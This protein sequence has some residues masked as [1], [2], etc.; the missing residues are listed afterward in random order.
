MNHFYESC[1]LCGPKNIKS[2]CIASMLVNLDL[3][4]GLLIS[5]NVTSFRVIPSP[6]F[7]SYAALSV[8]NLKRLFPEAELEV[9]VGN[10]NRNLTE[11]DAAVR[12][13]IIAHADRV[14]DTEKLHGSESIAEILTDGSSYLVCFGDSD[15]GFSFTVHERA[16]RRGL[17]IITTQK[18]NAPVSV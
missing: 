16:A 8:L 14:I 12:D 11:T 17:Q 5:Q 7:N 18:T 10:F 9:L 6:G 4:L 13:F 3:E 2:D 1:A 15:P